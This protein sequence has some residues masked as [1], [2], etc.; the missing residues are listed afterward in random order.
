MVLN[1]TRMKSATQ[2]ADWPPLRSATAHL[3]WLKLSPA[4]ADAALQDI[5]SPAERRRARQLRRPGA[6]SRFCLGRAHLRRILGEYLG[7][8]PESL[9]F[10]Y[11]PNGKPYLPEAPRLS[12]NLAHAGDL[13][14]LA[15]AD[16]RHVGADVELPG[17]PAR[18][19]AIARRCLPESERRRLQALPEEARARAVQRSW[20]RQEAFLK[21]SDQA[22]LRRLLRLEMPCA[23]SPG[24]FTIRDAQGCHWL[25]QDVARAGAIGALVV[26]HRPNERLEVLSFAWPGRERL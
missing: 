1:Q 26:E 23:A 3:W 16:G 24:Q 13:G 5:L 6:A 12:F 22:S 20:T 4:E 7:A 15:V 18:W 2:S 21:A 10:A 14:L 11:T 25:A 9:Q 17:P 19:L 8:P